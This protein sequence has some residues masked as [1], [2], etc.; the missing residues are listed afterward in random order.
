LVL[1]R[2]SRC[3]TGYYR[4]KKV[5]GIFVA[6]VLYMRHHVGRGGTKAERGTVLTVKGHT[7]TKSVVRKH[8]CSYSDPAVTDKPN[9]F[10]AEQFHSAFTA[11]RL[12]QQTGD[13]RLNRWT[14]T[15]YTAG[16]TFEQSA[17]RHVTRHWSLRT[18]WVG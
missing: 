16:L 18:A 12:P 13:C 7:N 15:E 6:L 3:L 14:R 1:L 8:R 10:S 2:S 17:L 4:D 9:A 11:S 5:D